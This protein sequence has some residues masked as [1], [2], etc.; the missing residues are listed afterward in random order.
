MNSVDAK[1]VKEIAQLARLQF[2]NENLAKMQADMSNMLGFVN[3]LNELDTEGIEP[4]IYMSDE[5]NV[6]RE[7]EVKSEITQ[8]EALMNAPKKDSDYFKAPK[9]IDK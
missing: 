6:L 3:K 2:E 1:T 7:D 5:V 8:K 9:V 4:L